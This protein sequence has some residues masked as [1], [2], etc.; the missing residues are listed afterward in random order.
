MHQKKILST[1]KIQQIIKKE[2]LKNK[3]I[4]MCHGA[5]DIMHVGHLNHF[6]QL[7]L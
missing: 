6:Q 1:D 2:K 5:F 7:P 4:V 3:K